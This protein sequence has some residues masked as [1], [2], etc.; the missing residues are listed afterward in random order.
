MFRA[1]CAPP[2][3]PPFAP[4]HSPS[5]APTYLCAT[6]GEAE[7]W[8]KTGASLTCVAS[9]APHGSLAP[10]ADAATMASPHYPPQVRLASLALGMAL[11]GGLAVLGWLGVKL[12]SRRKGGWRASARCASPAVHSPPE[13]PHIPYH[14]LEASPPCS[15]S[16][17]HAMP[18]LARLLT[19][20]FLRPLFCAPLPAG[21]TSASPRRR[22]SIT[23]E[24]SEFFPPLPDEVVALLQVSTEG[25]VKGRYSA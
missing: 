10:L 22:S 8:R 3:V 11:G 25:L 16:G 23:V 20:R 12:W 18:M 17:N 9:P 7:A 1:P 6:G 21:L 2:C 19:R 5:R 13:P 15:P 4:G 24:G 14:T